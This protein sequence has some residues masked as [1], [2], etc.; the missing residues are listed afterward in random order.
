MYIY[1]N[2]HPGFINEIRNIN[3]P[4]LQRKCKTENSTALPYLDKWL[5][6]VFR[7]VEGVPYIL[8]SR[9]SYIDRISY[10]ASICNIHVTIVFELVNNVRTLMTCGRNHVL[11]TRL[12]KGG[13]S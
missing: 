13:C 10:K 3:L 11:M 4:D 8:C 1:V 7:R 2:V 6:E 5:T 9:I 12:V